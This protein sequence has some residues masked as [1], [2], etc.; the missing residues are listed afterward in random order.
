MPRGR[1]EVTTLKHTGC[2]DRCPACLDQA[3]TDTLNNLEEKETRRVKLESWAR[4]AVEVL[5][6]LVINP[7]S[8]PI[9]TEAINHIKAAEKLGLLGAEKETL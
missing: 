5:H 2:P 8:I 3:F 1:E 4:K 9:S 7:M 6:Q